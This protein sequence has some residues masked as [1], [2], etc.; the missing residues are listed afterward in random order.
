M[1]LILLLFVTNRYF[2]LMVK[3]NF[4]SFT[5]LLEKQASY[6]NIQLNITL[7]LFITQRF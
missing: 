2:G 1:N 3:Q 5:T 6:K 4:S 7:L